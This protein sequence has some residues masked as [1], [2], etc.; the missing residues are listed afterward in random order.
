MLSVT[1][2]CITISLFYKHIFFVINISMHA[3]YIYIYIYII[4]NLLICIFEI[5]IPSFLINLMIILK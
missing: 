2:I 5:I 1:F 3:Y 4:L